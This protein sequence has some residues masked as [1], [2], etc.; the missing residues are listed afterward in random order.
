MSDDLVQRLCDPRDND[1]AGY[2]RRH[3]ADHIQVLE[4][5]PARGSQRIF[6]ARAWWRRRF[7]VP[8]LPPT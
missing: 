8:I 5:H 7:P 6:R 3:A 4:H 1:T 2:L